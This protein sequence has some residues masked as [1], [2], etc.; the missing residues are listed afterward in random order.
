MNVEEIQ[1]AETEILKDVQE[2]AFAK[3]K[4]ILQNLNSDNVR[5][6]QRKLKNSAL[7]QLDPVLCQDQSRRSDK[8][9]E[10]SL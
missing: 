6:R 1:T 3:E 10:Y 9:G 5:S 8:K 2:T 7:L 4:Q